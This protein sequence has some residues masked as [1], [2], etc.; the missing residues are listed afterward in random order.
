MLIVIEGLDGAGKST[1]VK[2][3]KEYILSA[4]MDLEY[5]HFPR[6]E[7]PV[8]GELI[9]KF[10]SGEFGANDQVH[11]QL[12]ALLFAL[13]RADAGKQI[14]QWLSNGKTVL[15]D[16]YVNSNIAYQCSKI[17]DREKR[18]ALMEWIFKL[19]Y[20][21][22][23]IPR[24]DINIFLDVP[25]SFVAK[26]LQENREGEERNYLHGGSDIHEASIEFQ[27]GVRDIYLQRCSIDANFKRV[28]CSTTEGTMAAPDV[29]FSR[30]KDV[31]K[32]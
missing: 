26:K 27:K 4:G 32:F 21:I 23:A 29:I 24:P 5:L 8:Y 19:E 14:R 20:E 16:R 17:A 31:L 6:Y 18:N 2:M 25:I 30:I 7:A 10:L 12:V 1:Q 13:D 3:V 11:P 28:N 15:L 22:Y 9:G